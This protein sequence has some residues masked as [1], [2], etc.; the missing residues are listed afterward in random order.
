M[1][2]HVKPV[3]FVSRSKFHVVDERGIPIHDDAR[4]GNDKPVV[5]ND[6]DV[7]QECADSLNAAELENDL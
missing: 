5:F 3:S 1:R 7:A 2:Y 6:E 4:Y